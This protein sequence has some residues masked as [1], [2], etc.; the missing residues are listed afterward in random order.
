MKLASVTRPEQ[1]RLLVRPES[2]FRR[3]LELEDRFFEKNRIQFGANTC[4]CVTSELA[5]EV[6]V[7]KEF[8]ATIAESCCIFSY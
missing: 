1:R 7:S 5:P 4:E 6:L 3:W 8:T 2:P